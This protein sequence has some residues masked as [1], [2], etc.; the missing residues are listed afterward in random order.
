MKKFV[1]ELLVFIK[2]LARDPEGETLL[3]QLRRMGYEWVENVRVGKIYRFTVEAEDCGEAEKRVLELG[4]RL[5]FYNPVVHIAE[6]RC[7]S[8]PR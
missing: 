1:V 7:L 8:E 3:E 4:G 2:P 5:R 6:A